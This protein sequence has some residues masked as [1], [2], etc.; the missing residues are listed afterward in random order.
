MKQ[1][2]YFSG[3]KR[4]ATGER[5]IPEGL[6]FMWTCMKRLLNFVEDF[7]QLTEF[8][9]ETQKSTCYRLLYANFNKRTYIIIIIQPS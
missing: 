5:L 4:S 2:H 9:H 1:L 8:Y 3:T 6:K 7:A